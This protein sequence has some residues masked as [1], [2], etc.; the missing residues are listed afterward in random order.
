[1]TAPPASSG[2]TATASLHPVSVTPRTTWLLVKRGEGWGELSDI[3]Q[4]EAARL[5]TSTDRLPDT[6]AGRTVAGGLATAAADAM[7]RAADLPLADWLAARTGKE[8]TR[9]TVPLYANI[10]RAVRARTP[11]S[12]AETAARAVA[13]GYDTVKIAPWD[14]LTGPDRVAEG[15]RL[16]RATREAIGDERHLLLDCHHLL[17]VD[18]L[19]DHAEELAE[20]RLGWLEDTAMLDDPD[21]LRAVRE[22]TRTPLAGG[23]FAASESEVLPALRSGALDVLMPDVKHAAGPLQVLRL[24]DL[25]ARYGIAV[26]LHNPS[27]PV[28]TAASAH[29]SALLPSTSPPL[30]TMFGEVEWRAATVSPPEPLTAATYSLGPRSGIGVT[31]T[32]HARTGVAS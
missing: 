31:P 23:E 1:M 14:G 19:L 22:A 28:A 18:E 2:C 6:F 25:A 20:L 10:N 16:A 4:D 15:L 7:A 17:T 5:L 11:T 8:V 30:E 12:A 9:R 24:A 3:P 32:A 27:G 26:S 13:A 21:G 29:L